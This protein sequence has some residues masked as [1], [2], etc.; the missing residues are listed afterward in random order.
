MLLQHSVFFFFPAKWKDLFLN[1]DPTS[2]PPGGWTLP[3]SGGLPKKAR[4][5]VHEDLGLEILIL[6]H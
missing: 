3:A 2:G 5:G 1:D 6:T 4:R